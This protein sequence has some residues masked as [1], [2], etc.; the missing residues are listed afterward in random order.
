MSV[1]VHDQ[2]DN[3][4]SPYVETYSFKVRNGFKT[5][6]LNG[7]KNTSFYKETCYSKNPLDIPEGTQGGLAFRVRLKPDVMI[8][9]LMLSSRT[10]LLHIQRTEARPILYV[11]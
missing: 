4:C 2:S 1:Y 3:Y 7:F 5:M 10:T 6:L 8:E 11:C 9:Q